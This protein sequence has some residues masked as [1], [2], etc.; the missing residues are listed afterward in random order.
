MLSSRCVRYHTSSS[1]AMHRV[2]A[3]PAW[4]Q[5]LFQPNQPQ[6]PRRP[7][8]VEEL[9]EL[10]EADGGGDIGLGASKSLQAQVL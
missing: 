1:R 4:A 8:L 2:Q 10:I 9:L 5:Q 7:Q 6:K 3:W